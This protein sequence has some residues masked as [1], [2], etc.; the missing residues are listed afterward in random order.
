LE[1][2]YQPN[3]PIG[4]GLSSSAAVETAFA[5]LW[6]TI[7]EWQIE[8]MSLAKICQFAENHYMG[9]N[10]G[11]MDQF[12]CLHGIVRHVLFL[13][14]RSLEWQPLPLPPGI[15]LVIADSGVRR[16]LAESRYKQRRR[17]CDR[18]GKS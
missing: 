17:N 7:G 8:R 11:I 15:S 1:A 13:D 12:A 16:S 2:A 18:A 9:V 5:V 4:A 3:L 14:V 6:Q 10:C